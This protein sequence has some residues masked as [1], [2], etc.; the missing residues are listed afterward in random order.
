M[1]RLHSE[2]IA[3]IFSPDC[4]GL[5]E[6]AKLKALSNWLGISLEND[7][8]HFSATEFEQI[9]LIIGTKN[10]LIVIEIKIKSSVHSNQLDRYTRVIKQNESLNKIERTTHYFLLSLVGED[11][12]KCTKDSKWKNTGFEDLLN[13][14]RANYTPSSGNNAAIL[15][16]YITSITA[17]TQAF[18]AFI[19]TPHLF[20]FVFTEGNR[21]KTPNFEPKEQHSEKPD[22]DITLEDYI[23]QNQLQTIFQKAYLNKIASELK[24]TA[25]IV[26][27]GE[28]HGNALLDIKSPTQCSA[29]LLGGYEF[30]Y[31]IQFQKNSIKI[32]I[33][34]GFDNKGLQIMEDLHEKAEQLRKIVY[35]LVSEFTNNGSEWRFNK[36]K[37]NNAYCSFSK[38]LTQGV[39]VCQLPLE[40]A[41]LVYQEAYQDAL[42]Q[43]Q[44]L[45][46]LLGNI[47]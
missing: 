27:V 22:S 41:A 35:P 21:K 1:E 44:K 31:G 18:K 29:I 5:S 28:T 32:Q 20:P 33:E 14:L 8:I 11:A 3:W 25:D 13:A 36:S 4:D 34:S 19:K 40:E 45:H 6:K 37:N 12:S 24:V 10:H 15:E 39:P 47:G 16:E 17:L 46:A 38:T 43:L 9:D 30:K 2:M 26:L 42:Q 7:S 23:R